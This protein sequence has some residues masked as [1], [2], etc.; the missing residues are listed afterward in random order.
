[1]KFDNITWDEYF[2]SIAILSSYRSKDNNT[3]ELAL[4]TLTKNLK[5]CNKNVEKIIIAEQ[6]KRTEL[7]EV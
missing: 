2:M 4:D 5:K 7:I 1:M 6:D 3:K